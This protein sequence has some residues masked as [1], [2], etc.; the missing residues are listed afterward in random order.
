MEAQIQPLPSMDNHLNVIEYLYEKECPYNHTYTDIRHCYDVIPK[1]S[2]S[3]WLQSSLT[4]DDPNYVDVL[5]KVSVSP[6]LHSTLSN[7]DPNYV[8]VLPKIS[9]SP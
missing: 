7:D 3:P 6:W 2:V 4:K 9:V 8:D 1:V 5:P